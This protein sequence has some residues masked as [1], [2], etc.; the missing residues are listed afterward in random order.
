[1]DADSIGHAHVSA[2]LPLLSQSFDY[3]VVDTPAG[4]DERTLAAIEC[5][6][7]LL[8]VSSLDVTSIR[9]LRKEL[10]ALD[11]M[12]VRAQ[13]LFVL[14][15]SDARVGL[16]PSDA[17]EAV[18]MKIACSLPSSREIPLSMNLGKPVVV[19]EPKSAVA[20]QLQQLSQW[21]APSDVAEKARKGWRR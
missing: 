2:V 21:Y 17:E 10:D 5:A 8:A 12:H 6:T 9:S 3:V 14:N 16:E 15:R 20:R 4:L 7:D 18:G 19:R 11:Q 13:R 1:M